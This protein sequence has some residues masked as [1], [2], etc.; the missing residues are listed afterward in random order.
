MSTKT[1]FGGSKSRSEQR[2]SAIPRLPPVIPSIGTQQGSFLRVTPTFETS[3]AP[4][5]SIRS[6]G[7]DPTISNLGALTGLDVNLGLAPQIQALREETLAGRRG[8]IGDVQGDIERLR[9]L[10]NP[11]IRARVQ[12]FVEQ[13]EQAAREA[14]RRGVSGPLA[15]LATNP[16]TAQIADQQALAQFDT[17][18][19]I[20]AGQ[21]QVQSLLADVSGEGQQLLAQEL[22]LLGLSQQQVRDIINSQLERQI[23]SQTDEKRRQEAGIIPSL[24][25]LAG[26]IGGVLDFFR[27]PTPPGTAAVQTAGRARLN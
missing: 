14:A 19:A 4:V 23:V 13:R 9:G 17:Q 10:E 24:G 1:L 22:E 3:G 15:A 16:F 25:S 2:V 20:R 5:G 26:G 8:L 18:A 7:T 21:Q 12:P 11:F 27:T 6:P